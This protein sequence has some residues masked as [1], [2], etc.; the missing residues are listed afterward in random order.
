MTDIVDSHVH[1][2]DRTRFRYDWLAGAGDPLEADFGPADLLAAAPELSGMVFV[3]ADCRADQAV[4]EARWVSE[5]AD[6]GAPVRA[7]VA[8]APLELGSRVQLAELTRISRVVGIRRLLQDEGPGFALQ[9]AFVDGVRRLADFSFSMDLC[10]RAH[11]L[12]EVTEL[13]TRCPE[14]QFVLDH[15]GKPVVGPDGPGDWATELRALADRP[16][17]QC[18]LSGLLGEAPPAMRSPAA[19]APWIQTALEAF[20]TDRCMF[21]SDW[22]VLTAF[23]EYADWLA[24][25]DT[26]LAGASPEERADVFADTASRFYRIT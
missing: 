17:V 1:F 16:N 6:S 15:L 25:V 22:P 3:Q 26:A 4:A 23:G 18:K 14:V 24:V 20:G 12:T 8:H 13:V 21:G 11:Q 19:L 10:I 7:I 2:W 5:L 9:E